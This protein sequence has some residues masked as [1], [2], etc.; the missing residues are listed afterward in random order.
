MAKAWRPELTTIEQVVSYYE[1]SN[2]KR[3]KVFAGTDPVDNALRYEFEGEDKNEGVEELANACKAIL[4][5][6]LNINTYLL[7]IIKSDK[8]I[9]AGAR[10]NGTPTADAVNI[11]FQLNFQQQLSPFVAS[12]QYGNIAPMQIGANPVLDAMNKQTEALNLI[13]S[14]LSAEE[15]EEVEY[16][17]EP[18]GMA[19]ILNGYLQ[20]N[21]EKIIGLILDKVMGNKP[22]VSMAGFSALEEQKIFDAIDILKKHDERLGTHLVKLA[23]IAEQNNVLFNGILTQLDTMVQEQ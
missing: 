8:I 19:G 10:K 1:N 2:Y 18:K 17:E 9:K 12:Q 23:A 20:A 11:T 22:A 14:K 6:P 7:Q 5:N 13:I 4:A 21:G 3:Y 16:V 15:A